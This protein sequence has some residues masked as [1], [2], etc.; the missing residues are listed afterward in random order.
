MSQLSKQDPSKLDQASVAITLAAFSNTFMKAVL[1]ASIGSKRLRKVI[2]MGFAL[3]IA[4]GV[5]GLII[6]SMMM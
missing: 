2:I 5:A 3:I 6:D 1:A 4:A